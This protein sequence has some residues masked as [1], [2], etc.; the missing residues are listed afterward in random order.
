VIVAPDH[1]SDLHR[2]VVR[3]HGEVV[4]RAPI[5]PQNDEVVEIAAL[6]ADRSCTASSQAIS[7]SGIRAG[8]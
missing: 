1:V 8:Y 4:D 6:E 5:A 7:S 2:D 3:Y